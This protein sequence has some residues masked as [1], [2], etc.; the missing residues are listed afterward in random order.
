MIESWLQI[1][2][3][4]CGDSPEGEKWTHYCPMPNVTRADFRASLKA[5]GWRSVG[6]HDYCPECVKRG[7]HR[8]GK[9]VFSS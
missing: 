8:A 1:T 4:G 6:Q 5:K 2:C 3:D 7:T 9:S